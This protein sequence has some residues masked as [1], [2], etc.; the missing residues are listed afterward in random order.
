MNY[1]TDFGSTVPKMNI[2]NVSDKKNT[3]VAS[4]IS[5]KYIVKT[6]KEPKTKDIEITVK[7]REL[8]S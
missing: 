6:N 3:L 8:R 5:L 7:N 4:K 2:L 1:N